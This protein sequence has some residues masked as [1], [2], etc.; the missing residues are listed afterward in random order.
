[1]DGTH[2]LH[3]LRVYVLRNHATLARDVFQHLMKSLRFDLLAFEFRVS[4]IEV[5][6]DGALMQ[7]LDEELGTFARRRF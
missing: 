6:K 7:F 1:M 5:E 2:H 4:V 3:H